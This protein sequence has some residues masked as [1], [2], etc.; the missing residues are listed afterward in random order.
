MSWDGVGKDEQ[1]SETGIKLLGG[2]RAASEDDTSGGRKTGHFT[3]FGG[4]RF[5]SGG[6]SGRA[7]GKVVV[8]GNFTRTKS[9]GGLKASA[10]Y[11]ATRANEHGE[12]MEREAFGQDRGIMNRD[13]VNVH[14]EG[15]VE[16]HDVHYRMVLSPGTD[17]EGEGVDL[18][19]YAR[20]MLQELGRGERGDL[21]WV[22][23]AHAG[24]TA[25]TGRA[26]VHLIVSLDRQLNAQ[27]FAQFRENATTRWETAKESARL[28]ERDAA[29]GRDV[30][31]MGASLERTRG[32]DR[33]D[34]RGNEEQKTG[35]T[36]ADEDDTKSKGRGRGRG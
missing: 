5:G 25:H 26:H 23:F 9:A 17:Q 3:G 36:S 13:D 28:L 31:E 30:R 21:T 15:A 10:R 14:L 32:A 20:E 16:K 34:G 22:G 6:G 27:D 1:V 35:A 33:S 29:A 11:Y 4:G 19:E 2:K 18:K 24:E 7:G 8:K 12:K